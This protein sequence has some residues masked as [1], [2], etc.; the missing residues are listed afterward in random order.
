[1]INGNGKKECK[2][3]EVNSLE[4]ERTSFIIYNTKGRLRLEGLNK[5]YDGK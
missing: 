4:Q 5:L 3:S 1:M 2:T